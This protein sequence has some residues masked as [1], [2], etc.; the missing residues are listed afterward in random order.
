[1]KNTELVE[2][3]IDIAE[4]YNTLYIM[5]CF[6]APISSANMDRYIN[7]HSF[8]KQAPRPSMIK[9]AANKTPRVFGFDCVNL[10]KGVLWGWN[11]DQAHTYG[12]AKYATNGVPDINADG[13]IAKCSGVSTTG[14]TDM[15]PGEVVWMSGHIG[16]YIGDGL[17]V[18]CTPAWKNCVQITAVGNIGPKSG[19]NTRKWTKHGKLPYVTYEATKEPSYTAD[20]AAVQKRFGFDNSTMVFLDKHPYPDAL[21]RKLAT[22]G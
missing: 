15:V 14:W 6:G 5:G 11:G 3:L 1:M 16:V 2:K 19:Y 21:Y 9:A 20:R 7:N 4:N 12:G 18:E 22:K 13:M 8:N 17:A 10:I